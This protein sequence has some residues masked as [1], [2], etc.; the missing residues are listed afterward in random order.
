MKLVSSYAC[1]RV[2][3]LNMKFIGSIYGFAKN[4][5]RLNCEHVIP[6]SKFKLFDLHS[7]KIDLNNLYPCC[8]T[9]NSM[10]KDYTFAEDLEDLDET[11]GKNIK[12]S[13]HI[14]KNIDTNQCFFIPPEN[15]RGRIARTCLH[16]IHEHPK[17]AP[18]IFNQVLNQELIL[19]WNDLY[20]PDEP[21]LKRRWLI[22]RIQQ[23]NSMNYKSL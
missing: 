6:Q 19:K 14:I 21:E 3:T 4:S 16:I 5:L 18:I 9:M 15:G 13:T 8:Q 23:D 12:L 22:Q 2:H 1:A 7:L 17:F 10:R 11:T 20:E